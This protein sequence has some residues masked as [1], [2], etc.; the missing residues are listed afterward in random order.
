[1]TKPNVFRKRRSV[2]KSCLFVNGQERYFFVKIE[3]V[4]KTSVEARLS[5][6]VRRHC[7]AT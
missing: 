5:E 1:M 7:R 3:N 6:N 4:A 2:P